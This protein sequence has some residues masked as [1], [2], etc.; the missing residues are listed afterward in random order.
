M[1]KIREKDGMSYKLLW[2]DMKG[3]RKQRRLNR[4]KDEEGRIVEGE[5]EVLEV[6]ARLWEELGRSSE[7]DVVQDTEM[8]DVAGCKLCMCEEV[9]WVS[10]VEVV[11]VLKCFEEREGS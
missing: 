1:R 3:K 7:D 5:D 9:S 6:L 4:M 10:W 2:T 11:D 8:G